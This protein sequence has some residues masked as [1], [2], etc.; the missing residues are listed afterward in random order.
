MYIGADLHQ[1]FCYMTCLDENGQVVEQRSIANQPEALKDYVGRWPRP[2]HMAV[3]ASS[4]TATFVDLLS[5][6][7]DRIVVVHPQRVKAIASAKLKNDKVDSQ[8]LA[9]LLRAD[10]LP[11]AWLS[12]PATRILREQVRLRSSL[13]QQRTRWKNQVHSTL[14]RWGQRAHV[15]DLFGQSGRAWLSA[16][17]LP[18]AARQT[19]DTQLKLIDAVDQQIADADKQMREIAQADFDARVLMTIPGIGAFSALVVKAEVGNIQRFSTKRQLYSYA[20]LVPWVRDSADHHRRGHITR[21]GSPLLRW[22]MAEAA[23]NAVR[24]SPGAREYFL[25]LAKRKPRAVARVALAR[26]LL[27]VVWA[28]WTHGIC[29]DE[30]VF[31]AV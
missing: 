7:A 18:T 28:L 13:V 8:T 4:S 17:V 12:D 21:A 19:V 5:P 25:R 16:L 15:T 11:T 23:M 30:Q 2:I 3:E 6:L 31:A 20:G 24:S 9:Q 27:G 26:K 14:H 10:L 29:F 1:R 22:V